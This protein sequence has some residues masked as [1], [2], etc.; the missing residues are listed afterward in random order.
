MIPL[1]RQFPYDARS[2]YQ[3][4]LEQ[5]RGQEEGDIFGATIIRMGLETGTPTPFTRKMLKRIEK[6]F[7]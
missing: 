4:D 2:S 7:S 6:R 1:T 5:G 3:R